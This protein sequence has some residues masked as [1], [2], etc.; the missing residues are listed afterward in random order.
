MNISELLKKAEELGSLKDAYVKLSAA[1]GASPGAQAM[2]LAASQDKIPGAPPMPNMNIQQEAEQAPVQEDELLKTKEELISAKGELERERV[3][4]RE[5][6]AKSQ[7]SGAERKAL[8]EVEKARAALES[9]KSQWKSQ[10]DSQTGILEAEKLKAEAEALRAETETRKKLDSDIL[11]SKTQ[12]MDDTLKE[13]EKL[14]DRMLKDKDKLHG[15]VRKAEDKIRTTASGDLSGRFSGISSTLSGLRK[16]AEV[17]IPMPGR[18][19]VK[20]AAYRPDIMRNNQ[21]LEDNKRKSQ[22]ARQTR[23]ELEGREEKTDYSSPELQASHQ[24]QMRANAGKADA[25]ESQMND[26]AWETD[27]NDPSKVVRKGEWGAQR[28]ANPSYQPTPAAK[29]TPSPVSEANPTGQSLLSRPTTSPQEPQTP[30]TPQPATQTPAVQTA[31]ATPQP[32]TFTEGNTAQAPVAPHPATPQAAPAAPQPSDV[33]EKY[34]KEY[35]D[36]V[37]PLLREKDR[38]TALADESR[39]SARAD[40]GAT[41]KRYEDALANVNSSLQGVGD[42]SS[43][44]SGAQ[45]TDEANQKFLQDNKQYEG[46][47]LKLNTPT[48]YSDR[49][50][51]L[52]QQ[53]MDLEKQL[54]SVK[55]NPYQEKEIQKQLSTVSNELN[56]MN[57]EQV[58]N[59][60]L[61][62]KG[63]SYLD[64][65]GAS[66]EMMEQNGNNMLA[67]KQYK[68]QEA[69][70]AAA[71]GTDMQK[72]LAAE[73]RR[74]LEQE[75]S[76]MK[77]NDRAGWN[78]A[79]ADA[80]I[81]GRNYEAMQKDKFMGQGGL[82]DL[83]TDDKYKNLSDRERLEYMRSMD[84][85]DDWKDDR[86]LLD[87][88]GRMVG[89]VVQA[90]SKVL[91][92]VVGAGYDAA[93]LLGN[94]A[95]DIGSFKGRD[96]DANTYNRYTR[97]WN[98]D[99]NA[100]NA[101]GGQRSEWLGSIESRNPKTQANSDIR[102]AIIDS[103]GNRN[104]LT[105]GLSNGADFASKT[106]P[107]G[108]V[109]PAAQAAYRTAQ[110]ATTAG[111]AAPL[112]RG[113]ARGAWDMTTGSPG[114]KL[115]R[116][117]YT[118]ANVAGPSAGENFYAK[119]AS[120]S[121]FRKLASLIKAALT[122]EQLEA[123]KKA[124]KVSQEEV[125]MR[126][127]GTPQQKPTQ[128]S[129]PAA[130]SLQNTNP[131]YYNKSLPGV[132]QGGGPQYSSG[133]SKML[134]E[135][136]IPLAGS[137]FG[138]GNPYGNTKMPTPTNYVSRPLY[139]M[140]QGSMKATYGE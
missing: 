51:T 123:I 7:I 20:V 16:K 119:K 33:S 47:T 122:P 65:S 14:A 129:S 118:G 108:K 61:S 49:T 120:D 31:P 25:L 98:R 41:L 99:S 78:A 77:T 38:L 60:W 115:T 23:Q 96:D 76:A 135:A 85:F 17:V 75:E 37:A 114:G 19:P 9:E 28:K 43:Y 45:K 42:E 91:A 80:V 105:F 11:K 74:N 86:G 81:N 117:I 109:L 89:N 66:P 137:F 29:P 131:E 57:N 52:N 44:V 64:L 18:A 127:G 95:G 50:N 55:Y 4:H 140:P 27:P 3:A 101:L 113:A 21:I 133:I 97:K 62:N 102:H 126:M 106:L 111:K 56:Y 46:S 13:R 59:Q 71:H 82:A 79:T 124:P 132:M 68:V 1:Q 30:P 36:K 5:T 92:N 48:E 6:E 32:K 10:Q 88:V 67:M 58:Q 22:Q 63:K 2:A 94:A 121:A 54:A 24:E 116:G 138:F 35:Y 134:F 128:T 107:A 103:G 130:V 83:Y 12:L 112:L 84:Y 110:A 73:M 104:G 70:A 15:E 72:R 53:K 93:G 26:T 125:D 87:N 100:I 136:G 34:K 90:P 8:S 139:A 40:G 69:E 39:A